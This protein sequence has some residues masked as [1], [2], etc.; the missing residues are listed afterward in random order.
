MSWIPCEVPVSRVEPA[1]FF[2]R[3]CYASDLRSWYVHEFDSRDA[4]A[5]LVRSLESPVGRSDELRVAAIVVEG[6]L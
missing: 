6:A 3:W 4:A 1:L 2:V 5:G